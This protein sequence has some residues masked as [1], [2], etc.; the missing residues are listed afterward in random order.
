MQVEAQLQ[1]SQQEFSAFLF[2]MLKQDIENALK[3]QVENVTAGFQYSKEIVNYM[4]KKERVHITIDTLTDGLYKASFQSTQGR[5][6]LTYAYE[7]NADGTLHVTYEEDY[8]GINSST[9]LSHKFMAF[10]TNRKNKKRAETLLKQIEAM[11][12]QQR[13]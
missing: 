1:V 12:V 6:S 4:Q 9:Q 11:I 10:V 8:Y 7:K 2:Q 3:K 13:G 5:N